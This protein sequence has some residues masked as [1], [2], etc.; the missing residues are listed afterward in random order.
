MIDVWCVRLDV[1]LEP[2]YATLTEDERNRSAR[3]RFERDR[4]RYIVARGALRSL[5]GQYL[6][7]EPAQI[8]FTYNPFGKPELHSDFGTRLKFNLSHSADL[9]AIAITTDGAVGVDIE[10]I[11]PEADYAEIARCDPQTFFEYW[12]RR[13]AYVKARGEGLQDGPIEF[14]EGWSLCGFEPEPGYI[15]AVAIQGDGAGPGVN[16]RTL[17]PML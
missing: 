3:F 4:R 1:A 17:R 13:E 2:Y 5:L 6:D 10:Q 8:R 16:R 14:A 7:T 12:T 11:K 15:G 9:A